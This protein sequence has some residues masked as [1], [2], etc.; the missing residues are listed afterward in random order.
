VSAPSRRRESGFA[1]LEAL[2]ALSMAALLIGAVLQAVRWVSGVSQ[3]GSRVAEAEQLEAG[4]AAVVNL[5]ATAVAT[6]SGPTFAGDQ[7]SLSFELIS[8]GTVMAPGLVRATLFWRPGEGGG[9]LAVSVTSPGEDGRTATTAL[10]PRLASVRIS[11]LG[12]DGP[13]A[14]KT[15]R[16]SWTSKAAMPALV[17]IEVETA[18][19]AGSLKIPLYARVG[20]QSGIYAGRV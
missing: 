4:S 17:L 9:D 12:Q 16:G 6:A 7:R 10:I 18:G 5:L 20:R 19:D 13:E 1:L 14:R 2:V 3:Y 11:Y 15:W 8:D